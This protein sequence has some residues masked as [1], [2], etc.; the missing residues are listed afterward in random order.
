MKADAVLLGVDI[1]LYGILKT[2]YFTV[3]VVQE[4]AVHV[5]SA[6]TTILYFTNPTNAT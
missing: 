3:Y 2:L 5:T 6:F 4:R 1:A